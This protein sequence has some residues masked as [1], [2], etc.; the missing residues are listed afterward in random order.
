MKKFSLKKY[1]F[2]FLFLLLFELFFA[3]TSCS[4][5]RQVQQAASLAKCDFQIRSVENVF[6]AGIFV[7]HIS[8]F[9]DLSIMDVG[10]LMTSLAGPD[11]PLSLQL[12]LA[13]R[14]PNDKPA[15]L[16]RIDWIIYIDD[17]QMTSG[18][19]EKA[20]VIPPMGVTVIPVIVNV[21]LKQVLQGKSAEALINFALNLSGKS[22]TPTRFKIKIKPSILIGQTAVPYP[23]YITVRTDYSSQ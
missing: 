21:N 4:V 6:L 12:N 2:L 18:S 23:G 20:F 16:D 7:Q 17:I 14:N 5:S 19:L 15:G 13:G 8:T 1:S 11:L 3:V 9:S 10:K 22:N